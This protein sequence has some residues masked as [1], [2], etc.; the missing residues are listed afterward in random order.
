V[1]QGGADLLGPAVVLHPGGEATDIEVVVERDDHRVAGHR[2]PGLHHQPVTAQDGLHGALRATGE[3]VG[4]HT[5]G[6]ATWETL[7]QAYDDA[8]LVELTM[9]VGHYAMLA[10]LLNAA[11][12]PRD[13]GVAGF[14]RG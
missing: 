5:V 14:P 11:Q 6:Q 12:V 7:K 2:Q 9:L 1:R 10:G 13:E 3:L 8:A 4:E